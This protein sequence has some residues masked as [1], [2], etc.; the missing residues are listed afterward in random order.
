MLHA[1]HP[2]IALTGISAAM[3]SPTS[4]SERINALLPELRARIEAA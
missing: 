4:F 2:L 1:Q 3:A